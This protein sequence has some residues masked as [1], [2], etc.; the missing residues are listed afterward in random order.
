[1]ERYSAT[2]WQTL[3]NPILDWDCM[4][5][6][7]K[8]NYLSSL[9]ELPRYAQISGYI[10]KIVK[11][12]TVLD[13]GCGEGI[14]GDYLDLN[15]ITYQG[16]DPSETAISRARA[17]IPG[18][19]FFVTGVD[20]YSPADSEEFDAI[21]FNEVL[22]HISDPLGALDRFCSFLR[23]RGIVLISLFQNPNERA[24]ASILT[25]MFDVEI[26][27]GRYNVIGQNNVD[28]VSGLTWRIYCI[29]KKN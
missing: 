14:L 28:N 9:N 15:R 8:W 24:N 6:E 1:M 27:H 25:K 16:F 5:K 4:F 26:Q 23:P 21:V 17:R 3:Y 12:G 2:L 29:G 7:N 10:H 11:S 20:D 18:A 22:P 19:N 13:A